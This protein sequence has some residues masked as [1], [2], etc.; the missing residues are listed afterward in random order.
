MFF[1]KNIPI[2]IK[3]F[4][5]IFIFMIPEISELKIRRKASG[6]T[7]ERLS[8]LSGVS[9]SLIAKIEAG[10]ISPGFEKAKRL[11]DCIDRIQEE[12]IVTAGK[13]MRKH[14]YSS[15]P[16]DSAKKAVLLM[17]K[18]GISQMPVIWN[19]H[20]FGTVTEK[21]VLAILSKSEK[22]IDLSRIKVQGIM[23]DSMPVIQ[24]ST[25]IN[26]VSAMLSYHS[27]VLVSKKGAI[28]GIITKSDLLKIAAKGR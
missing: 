21:G 24:E 13:I 27:G 26:I 17:E 16:K 12:K 10:N 14:L 3:G 18:H 25:P 4:G 19:G 5:G 28:T 9:Q 22:N 6:L 8:R 11:F 15:G 2:R 7:Q 23:E 20:A 1:E